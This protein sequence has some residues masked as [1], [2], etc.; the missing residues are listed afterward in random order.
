M[1]GN[2]HAQDDGFPP[3]EDPSKTASGGRDAAAG[4]KGR[5]AEAEECEALKLRR[6][7]QLRWV[8]IGQRTTPSSPPKT[9]PAHRLTRNV[10]GQV[11]ADRRCGEPVLRTLP[12]VFRRCLRAY[13]RGDV[14]SSGAACRDR[15]CHFPVVLA[16]RVGRGGRGALCRT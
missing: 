12:R 11:P 5:A 16:F 6:F 8:R 13:G 2:A 10:T 7:D 14:H 9:D 3:Q 1:R 4:E 15:L